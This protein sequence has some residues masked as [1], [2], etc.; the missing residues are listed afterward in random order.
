MG[1]FDA[2]AAKSLD[3]TSKQIYLEYGSLLFEGEIVMKAVKI[4]RDKLILTDSRLILVL[5]CRGDKYEFLSVPYSNVRKFSILSKG[6]NELDATLNIHLYGENKPVTKAFR[7]CEYINEIYKLLGKYI[8][9]VQ[10]NPAVLNEVK[11]L[12]LT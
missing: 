10:K 11:T 1:L 9:K 5:Q 12:T 6:I 7:N 8:S 2:F 3:I 4:D